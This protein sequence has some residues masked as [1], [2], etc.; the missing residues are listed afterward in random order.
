MCHRGGLSLGCG[1]SGRPLFEVYPRDWKPRARAHQDDIPT[2]R[3]LRVFLV[4]R[5][6]SVDK[7]PQL[8]V[9][10]LVAAKALQLVRLSGAVHVFHQTLQPLVIIPG[11]LRNPSGQSNDGS[12]KVRPGK[13]ASPEVFHETTT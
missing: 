2:G 3:R 6:V 1:S 10:R 13:T 7:E 12:V 4:A 9:L 11:P 5:E 8:Y